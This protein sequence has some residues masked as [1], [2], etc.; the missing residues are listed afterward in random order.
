MRRL[1]LLMQVGVVFAILMIGIVFTTSNPAT[2][3]AAGKVLPS[4]VFTGRFI[5]AFVGSGYDPSEAYAAMA[6]LPVYVISFDKWKDN[7]VAGSN[8][9]I[10]GDRAVRTQIRAD[11]TFQVQGLIEGDTFG[12]Y[13]PFTLNPTTNEIDRVDCTDGTGPKRNNFG[14]TDTNPCKSTDEF[15][16]RPFY[17]PRPDDKIQDVFSYAAEYLTPETATTGS[18]YPLYSQI[19][20]ASGYEEIS[21]EHVFVTNRKELDIENN[22]NTFPLMPAST[23]KV[24]IEVPEVT[25]ANYEL[26]A[27]RVS[28]YYESG[29]HSKVRRTYG[30]IIRGRLARDQEKTDTSTYTFTAYAPR[31]DYVMIVW[32]KEAKSPSYKDWDGES[33]LHTNASA[34]TQLAVNYVGL[35]PGD[36][37]W[38]GRLPYSFN[39][40]VNYYTNIMWGLIT[41]DRGLLLTSLNRDKG[42][43]GGILPIPK[44]R[45]K[46][47]MGCGDPGVRE[48]LYA[49]DPTLSQQEK[50]IK[51]D[52]QLPNANP[53]VQAIRGV[54]MIKEMYDIN[55]HCYDRPHAA[56]IQVRFDETE[57]NLQK[58]SSGF[59]DSGVIS[60]VNGPIRKDI[61]VITAQQASI[62]SSGFS[63]QDIAVTGGHTS[64]IYAWMKDSNGLPFS[65]TVRVYTTDN[66]N[67]MIAESNRYSFNDAG[68]VYIPASDLVPSVSAQY[69]DLQYLLVVDN[70][71]YSKSFLVGANSASYPHTPKFPWIT[72]NDGINNALILACDNLSGYICGDAYQ[73]TADQPRKLPDKYNLAIINKISNLINPQVVAAN[74]LSEPIEVNLMDYDQL[75]GV[76]VSIEIKENVKW[77][78]DRSCNDCTV[79]YDVNPN[80]IHSINGLY[81]GSGTLRKDDGFTGRVYVRTPI[82]N[83][84]DL[85][86]LCLMDAQVQLGAGAVAM[87]EIK[88]G[89]ENGTSP[90]IRTKH[91][92]I[93]MVA[94]VDNE[95][96]IAEKEIGISDTGAPRS[97]IPVEMRL[98]YN[99]AKIA[100]KVKSESIGFSIKE[101]IQAGLAYMGCSASQFFVSKI[102]AFFELLQDYGLQV[103]PLT[104][105]QAV[106]TLFNMSRNI[107]NMLFIFIFIVMAIMTILR[108]QPE[109]WHVRVVLPALLLAL[110]YANFSILIVQAILDLNNFATA[111]I[112]DFTA[113]VIK[114]VL[115]N[116]ASDAVKGGAGILGA[117]GGGFMAVFAGALANL[118]AGLV[119]FVFG[120]GGTGL[121]GVIGLAI[122]VALIMVIQA[123]ILIILFLIRLVIIW[124]L[125]IAAPFVFLLSA[126]PW[127]PGLR[128]QWLNILLKVSFIQTAVAALLA[129]GLIFITV[130]GNGS[131]F[132]GTVALVLVGLAAIKM[133]VDTPKGMLAS[134]A[135]AMGAGGVGAALGGM[136]AGAVA[137]GISGALGKAKNLPARW[138]DKQ[139]ANEEWEAKYKEE[140]GEAPGLLAK[141]KRNIK[142]ITGVPAIQRSFKKARKAADDGKKASR[143]T[144]YKESHKELVS[145]GLYRKWEQPQ[146]QALYENASS[147]D[148]IIDPAT[149]Q[150]IGTFADLSQYVMG[151][152]G[153]PK[154]LSDMSYKEFGTALH[155]HV[156]TI[157]A[158]KEREHADRRQRRMQLAQRNVEKV[159]AALER[160]GD[161]GD[162]EEKLAKQRKLQVALGKAKRRLAQAKRPSEFSREAYAAQ[163][164]KHQLDRSKEFGYDPM[165]KALSK[166]KPKE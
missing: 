93:K 3:N 125:L 105:N 130:S 156:Q 67:T 155:Q 140:H 85:T 52:Q 69:E 2:T 145:S 163:L 51:P 132:G 104:R 38:R 39:V 165:V 20:T 47:V 97:G 48:D 33:S 16:A 60:T 61:K 83:A 44:L 62:S 150:A 157:A 58:Y 138:A 121:I 96:R 41:E 28:E 66:A 43:S 64:G 27:I 84:T 82:P 149:G 143:T 14:G 8:T 7:A 90:F 120:T 23:I 153:K 152:D 35:T 101:E 162:D 49:P 109:K 158:N 95:E 5:P 22:I 99:C 110:V 73:I 103:A 26:Y 113:G 24:N 166:L 70:G 89:C 11:G 32:R 144:A 76:D 122:S 42:G 107:V 45:A 10:F 146:L 80:N 129:V 72:I 108:Y 63:Y 112:F 71:S 15:K 13:F 137:G 53:I 46:N 18:I 131:G 142:N 164:K 56:R 134:V 123:A 40:Y 81:R 148:E 36:V 126:T 19:E 141:G 147:S 139:A 30:P 1:L 128:E 136:S 92:K 4:S 133:A 31:G 111:T 9:W 114:T 135:S 59:T 68:E 91:Y 159:Q 102:D 78:F 34:I 74:A 127:F 21:L 160:L 116:S 77:W 55:V 88:E 29:P 65:G 75:N 17:M 54:Y 115:Q 117:A 12:V 79:E 86:S 100:E 119:S 154:S 25:G 106:I 124:L 94:T 161:P 98:Y 57:P 37:T 87:K 151:A 6:G 118:T 50:S